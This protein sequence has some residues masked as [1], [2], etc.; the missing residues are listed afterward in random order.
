M[1][2]KDTIYATVI[3]GLIVS[4]VTIFIFTPIGNNIFKTNDKPADSNKQIDTS[5][6]EN[7]TT[8]VSDT[9]D[10]N[11]I[12]KQDIF[13]LQSYRPVELFDGAL[14]VTLNNTIEYINQS[15]ELKLVKK[16]NGKSEITK[17]KKVGDILVF[18]E[19]TILLLSLERN[20]STYDLRIK[21][22]KTPPNK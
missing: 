12:E 18:E 15:I 17:N 20:I 1:T 16:S 8:I 14:I 7:N 9:V 2:K 6:I 11:S 19:Y 5:S 13:Y 3:G 22:E 10:S 21:I 4:A